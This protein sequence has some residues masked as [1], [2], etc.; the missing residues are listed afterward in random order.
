[1]TREQYLKQVTGYI[2]T[3]DDDGLAKFLGD[4]RRKKLRALEL[5][6]LQKG[7]KQPQSQPAATHAPAAKTNGTKGISEGDFMRSIRGR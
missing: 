3:L 4:E 7:Q 6:Q 1:M 2:D 5:K